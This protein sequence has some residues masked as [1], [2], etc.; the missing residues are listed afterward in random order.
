M[1]GQ[2]LAKTHSHLMAP[3]D[4]TPGIPRSEY[5]ERREKLMESLP[6][7][8]LVVCLGGTIKYMSQEIFYKFRQASD[9][10]YLT[11][12]QEPDAALIL[13]K[14]SQ[15]RRSYKMTLFCEGKNAHKEKWEG[16]RTGFDDV[17]TLFGADEARDSSLFYTHLK[18]LLPLYSRYYV[19]PYS[20]QGRR[21]KRC[22]SLVPSSSVGTGLSLQEALDRALDEVQSPIPADLKREV[23]RFRAIKSVNEQT[24][25]RKAADISAM[26]HT[27]SMRFANMQPNL[28]E[29]SLAAHFEYLC[30]LEGAQR[31]AYVPVVASGANSLV[32]HYT[33]NDNLLQEGDLVLI[34]A[35]CEYNGYT[36]DITRTYPTFPSGRFTTAQAEIYNAVLVA[37]KHCTALC[38]ETSKMSMYDLHVESCKIL[39]REL[40]KLGFNLRE[41]NAGP[42]NAE[43][44]R[45]LYP[46]F[47]SHPIGIDLHEAYGN[48]SSAYS[49][50]Q[51][52]M[53]ITVEPG[54]YVPPSSLFPSQYHNIGVRIEDD[55]LIGKHD[56][57][58][59]S[60]NAPKE[61]VDVEAACQGTLGIGSY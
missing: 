6:E 7:G 41:G 53:V 31:M 22:R 56:P 15:G 33:S 26:A 40:N 47:L 29:A 20:V 12:F 52:G 17:V 32:I 4:L 44:E 13:E 36:S 42:G 57:V 10:W 24:V 28:P 50:L 3:H 9:F 30:T 21:R 23:A 58:V 18:G 59:L 60:V 49:S 48:R 2:P 34:D 37:L 45:I 19:S 43:V 25:L 14:T 1:Y 5:E 11:G 27:K 54:I 61:I 35:G 8:S 55:V 46:H 38:R 16:A 51:A 39:A